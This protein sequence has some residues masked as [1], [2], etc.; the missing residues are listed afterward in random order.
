MDEFSI[1][2]DQ[3]A[4]HINLMSA[5]GEIKA[6]SM[7]DAVKIAES[8][9]KNKLNNKKT[10]RMKCED[11]ILPPGQGCGFEWYIDP[12]EAY[13]ENHPYSYLSA[14][15]PMCGKVNKDAA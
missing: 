8:L 2:A 9:V 14:H 3:I 13:V 11:C 4:S 12:D 5:R 6:T 10:H 1:K 7:A 15:C